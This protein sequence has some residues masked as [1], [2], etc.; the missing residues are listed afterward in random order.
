MYVFFPE[1]VVW[2][3]PADVKRRARLADFGISRR[4]PK[5]QTSY[6]T[7]RAGTRCW[8][9]KETLSEEDDTKIPYKPNCDIQVSYFVTQT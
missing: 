7:S 8:M 5:D 6:R 9:A 1:F 4:L 2:I 3:F